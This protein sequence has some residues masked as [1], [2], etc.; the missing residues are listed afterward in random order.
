MKALAISSSAII[1]SVAVIAAAPAY[2]EGGVSDCNGVAQ[3]ANRRALMNCRNQANWYREVNDQNE[4]AMKKSRPNY[5]D[6]YGIGN[7]SRMSRICNQVQSIGVEW[8]IDFGDPIGVEWHIDFDD[9]IGSDRRAPWEASRAGSTD[10]WK[11]DC[12]T[13]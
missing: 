11:A 5:R 3:G 7:A 12:S 13:Y 1:L 4:G 10:R 9:P 6:P 8:H 2:A